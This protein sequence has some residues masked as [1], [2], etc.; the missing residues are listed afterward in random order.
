[1]QV[2]AVLVQVQRAAGAVT[3]DAACNHCCCCCRLRDLHRLILVSVDQTNEESH[4]HT[5]LEPETTTAAAA[6]AAEATVPTPMAKT[7]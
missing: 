6:A 4:F 2:L 7:F 5:L 3:D 1:V